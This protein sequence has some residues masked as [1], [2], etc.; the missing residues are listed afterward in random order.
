VYTLLING[1][2][3]ARIW[4]PT[5]SFVRSLNCN[6]TINIGKDGTSLPRTVRSTIEWIAQ[7][8]NPNFVIIPITLCTRWELSI[9][10]ADNLLD[11]TW[12][13]MQIR[14]Y[15]Q[16]NKISRDIDFER[17]EQLS[18]LYYASIPNC[19]TYYDRAFTDIITLAGFLDY[20]KID[21]LM[22][23]MCNNFILEHLIGYNGFH[24]IKFLKQ[25]KKI[26]DL[27]DFCGNR[28]MYESIQNEEEKNKTDP[29][30]HHHAS[31]QYRSL[32]QYLSSYLQLQKN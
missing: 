21:Y 17:L 24:K 5:D 4:N 20:K 23:D 22:F 25:N 29:Y 2:S 32:E 10:Q 16:K 8:G 9:A 11:G 15:L 28:F 19:R 3:F 14:E 6:Q 31:A 27:F 12:Y 30:M 13:P 1:C 18:D 26:I 7:N